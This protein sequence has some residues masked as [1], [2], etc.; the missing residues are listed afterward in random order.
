[1]PTKEGVTLSVNDNAFPE[2]FDLAVIAT[3]HVWPDEDEATRTFFPSPWSGLMDAEI[4]PCKV[5]IMGTSLSGLD[6]AMA[7]VMQHGQFVDDAFILDKGSEALKIVLMS[8][9]GICPRPILLPI[10]YEPL[11][12][13]TKC[14][15]QTEIAKGADGLLDRIFALMVKELELADPAWCEAIS[16]RQ[17]DADSLREAWF[18]ERKQHGPFTWAEENLKEVERNKRERRTVAWRYTIL[19]LHEIVAEIVPALNEKDRARFKAGLER[20]FIDNYA[21]IPLSLFAGCLPCARRAS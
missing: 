9:T 19:R 14:V 13:L 2:R 5:G 21:A 18:E 11:S 20:V 15:V 8:R 4:R 3:G 10:P 16:L 6:A 12:V 17:R 1:M 7:V